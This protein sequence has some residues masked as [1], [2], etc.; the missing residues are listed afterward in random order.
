MFEHPDV[1]EAL[2]VPAHRPIKPI[3]VQ[4]F[5]RFIEAIRSTHERD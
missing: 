4:R 5:V 1:I 2:S 3:Y